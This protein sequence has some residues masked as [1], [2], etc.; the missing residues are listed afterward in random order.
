MLT[1][2]LDAFLAWQELPENDKGYEWSG[3]RVTP[4]EMNSP[5]HERLCV[6]LFGLL[7]MQGCTV[8]G[9]NTLLAVRDALGSTEI[10]KPDV[11]VVCEPFE[12]LPGKPYVLTNPSAVVEVR[13]RST[14]AFCHDEKLELYTALPSLLDYLLVSQTRPRVTLVSRDSGVSDAWLLRVLGPGTTVKLA[15][16]ASFTVDALYD[17]VWALPGEDLEP[18]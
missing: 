10:R 5:R 12:S 14:S 11:T 7:E 4:M 8:L 18:A 13:S 17:G 3:G 15:C 16:G 9:S 1:M 2:S 6:K